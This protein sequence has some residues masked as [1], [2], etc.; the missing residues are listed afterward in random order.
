MDRKPV[1]PFIQKEFAAYE[2][3]RPIYIS[4]GHYLNQFLW[5]NYYQ[6]RYSTDD[7]ALYL[8]LKLHGHHGF[9]APLC[10]ESDLPEVF[11][12][13]VSQF[14]D[15]W[16]E[17]ARFYNADST[18][19]EIL[20][21]HGMLKHYEI[22]P[23]RDSFDYLYDADKLRTLSGKAMHKKK[24]LLNGFVRDYDGRFQYETLGI[25]DI[26]EIKNFHQKWMDER[27]IYDKYNC[28]DEE[29]DGI[30]RLFGNCRSIECKMGG[31]R[32]DGEL[33]AYTIGSYVPDIRLAIIH[34]EKADV[35]YRGLYNY[36]NREFLLHEFPEAV[37]VNREDDLGQENLRQAKLS[38]R[39]LRL[40]EKYTLR[41]T[42]YP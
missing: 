32:I 6:T 28:I 3:L 36:I 2:S 38:Y 15:V 20:K 39:P 4:E 9:F 30:Y 13:M 24:N 18:M 16:K 17:P 12:R 5:E 10:R 33:K 29:E 26:W 21:K 1:S 11:M 23:D 31:V 7:K 19:V 22:L 37:L 34:V 8:S 27:K 40:E 25:S 42:K 35:N 14:H 41:E